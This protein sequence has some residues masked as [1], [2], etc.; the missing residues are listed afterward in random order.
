MAKTGTINSSREESHS[1]N[2]N[3]IGT[4]STPSRGV[5]IAG[6]LRGETA[7]PAPATLL[8]AKKIN[9]A[10]LGEWDGHTID[11]GADRTCSSGGVG[12]VHR[13]F[14]ESAGSSE[15]GNFNHVAGHLQSIRSAGENDRE[16]RESGS[17][18]VCCSH[19]QRQG[20]ALGGETQRKSGYGEKITE[21]KQ[22]TPESAEREERQGASSVSQQSDDDR[23]HMSEEAPI[24]HLP[25]ERDM[26][27]RLYQILGGMDRM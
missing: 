12:G 7:A 26:K 13:L 11:S 9:S 18:C 20:G 19:K 25:G 4:R 1:C 23:T 14:L 27:S 2:F 21:S 16:E 6:E 8:A 17:N 15:C 24:G 5:V 22:N 10:C 3:A